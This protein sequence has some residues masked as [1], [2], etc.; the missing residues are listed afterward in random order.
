MQAIIQPRY[1]EHNMSSSSIK[2]VSS[3]DFHAVIAKGVTLVDFFAEWCGPCRMQVPVLE[4]LSQ[5]ME[6]KMQVC[7]LDIDQAQGIAEQFQVTSVPT[8][9]LFKDGKEINRTVGLHNLDQLR[10]F[11]INSN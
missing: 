8:L 5:E 10:E 1:E 6:D 2:K 11:V 3:E 7:K 9:I 4:E